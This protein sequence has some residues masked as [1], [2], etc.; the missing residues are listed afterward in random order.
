[1]DTI[2]QAKK[3]ES[4]IRKIVGALKGGRTLDLYNDREFEVAEFHTCICYIRKMLNRGQIPGYVLKDAWTQN[5]YGI[6]YKRYWF[7]HDANENQ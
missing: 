1:M 7:E 2:R 4:A 3:R 6:R 5:E